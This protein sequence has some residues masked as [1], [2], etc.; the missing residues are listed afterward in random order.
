MAGNVRN[1]PRQPK[2]V[3]FTESPLT[4]YDLEEWDPLEGFEDF[5][6]IPE[7]LDLG[8]VREFAEATVQVAK[9]FNVPLHNLSHS[10]EMSGEEVGD[11]R[12]D[13]TADPK[14]ACSAIVAQ[15][16]ISRMVTSEADTIISTELWNF[17]E[18]TSFVPLHPYQSFDKCRKS[19]DFQDLGF[20]D[21]PPLRIILD[22]MKGDRSHSSTAVGKATM[23]G[24]RMRTPR[25]EFLPYWSLA[26]FLQDGL[27]RTARSSEP[28]YLPQIMGGSGCRVPYGDPTNLHLYI[29][30]YKNGRCQRIYGSATRELR[31]SLSSLEEG[32]VIMPIL[33]RRLR[34]KQ[35]YLHGTYAE[36]VFVP[37]RQ[38]MSEFGNK[39]PEPLIKASGGSNLFTSFENRLIRSRHLVTRTSAEREWE[40]TTRIRAALLSRYRPIPESEALLAF[41][42]KRAR[43]E[44]GHALNANTALAHLLERK[45]SIQDVIALTN[46]NFHVVNCGATHFTKWDAEW[47]FFGGKSENFSIEDLSSSEDLFLRKEVSEE[48]SL[49][50]GSIPL[51]PLIRNTKQVLTT[52]TVGLY[53][54]GSGMYEWAEDLTRRLVSH[55]ERNG[56]SLSRAD[57]LEDYEV[58][59]EWVNDDTLIIA[60]CRR[61]T[62]GGSQRSTHVVLVSADKRLGHQLSNSCNVRVIRV[63]PVE[64]IRYTH[65]NAIPPLT[66]VDGSLLKKSF[67]GIREDTVIQQVYVDTGSVNAFLS[68]MDG[69][70]SR[71]LKIKQ[72]SR[73]S[74]DSVTKKRKYTYTLHDVPEI[75]SS[76]PYVIHTPT[77]VSKRFRLTPG[78]LAETGRRKSSYSRSSASSNW[79]R[80]E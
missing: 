75:Q 66:E 3:R 42:K 51:R 50:V 33:C 39:L 55:R 45:G 41:T 18:V 72:V 16:S 1:K 68:R 80:G 34:D 15:T 21:V 27:L 26:S 36:K 79:R 4:V 48:E 46:E 14:R 78:S 57:A 65:R 12:I 35:E 67:T 54:I 69:D 13:F 30:A 73:S 8:I 7:P 56:G 31:Q 77:L 11:D 10:D 58:N 59:P 19:G 40:F 71:G 61:D 23:L 20:V 32:K 62:G 17:C 60:R 52:T 9:H 63:H 38:Y 44:F 29:Y 24:S 22:V 28:K 70:T 49:K 47:L 37:T 64:Y 53:Q 76:V 74:V 25:T 43:A 5:Q 2:A 6:F